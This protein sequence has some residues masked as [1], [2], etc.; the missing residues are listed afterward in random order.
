MGCG[1]QFNNSRLVN[2]ENCKQSDAHI[3]L[4]EQITF[5]MLGKYELNLENLGLTEVFQN[6]KNNLES[7][8]TVTHRKVL[9]FSD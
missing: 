1:C 7:Y 4:Q 9:Y 3:W 8:F 6:L 2:I 5:S